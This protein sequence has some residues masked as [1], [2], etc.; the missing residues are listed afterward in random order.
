MITEIEF[1]RNVFVVL[2]TL[3][4]LSWLLFRSIDA[5]QQTADREVTRSRYAGMWQAI[6]R[7]GIVTLPERIIEWMIIKKE[8]Y[9]YKLS[10]RGNNLQ[11]Y[12]PRGDN[13]PSGLNFITN[14]LVFLTVL[15]TLVNILKIETLGTVVV[16]FALLFLCF[17]V[18][19]LFFTLDKIHLLKN[20]IL[21]NIWISRIS[22]SIFIIFVLIGFTMLIDFS[23]QYGDFPSFIIFIVFIPLSYLFFG[24]ILSIPIYFI[25][26]IDYIYFQRYIIGPSAF[27][28]SLSL[29]ITMLCI[30]IGNSISFNHQFSYSSQLFYT[31]V[32]FD[33]V[34]LIITFSLLQWSIKNN[35]ALR[36][37]VAIFL[38]VLIAAI[39]ACGSLYFGLLGTENQ[40]IL[41]EIFNILVGKSIDGS[42]IDLGPY[43]WAMHTTFIP[44]FLYLYF[45]F[46]GL[47]C[48]Y[49]TLPTMK[50]LKGVS[51]A[52]KPHYALATTFA[53]FAAFFTAI[54]GV[55]QWQYGVCMILI[56]R[57][58]D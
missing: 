32:L 48:K 16:K 23:L 52:E 49:L 9:T 25:N 57:Q 29:P 15:I 37:P 28:A 47:V 51:G 11:H 7:L 43:F 40:L 42:K 1:I 58:R 8:I 21:G 34:T 10:E 24:M 53:F 35:P 26:E 17:L 56:L 5:F 39:L 41:S 31:N 3:C 50:L 55:I 6:D 12:L 33:A 30:I 4:G 27:A 18:F 38:D 36:I 54:A 46:S 14:F 19:Y 45:I 20:P 44:T 22:I 13:N 2:S